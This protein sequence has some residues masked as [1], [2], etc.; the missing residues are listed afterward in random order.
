M[1]IPLATALFVAGA[2]VIDENVASAVGWG[3]IAGA[4]ALLIT[5]GTLHR[6]RTNTLLQLVEMRKRGVDIRNDGMKLNTQD[7]LASWI[8]VV[9]AWTEETIRQIG[10]V[11]LVDSEFFKTLNEVA[12]FT[13]NCRILDPQHDKWLREHNERLHRLE[14][15]IQK[16][17]GSEMPLG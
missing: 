7:K 14:G 2:R 5:M 17:G 6:R 9:S 15:L 12:P 13:L 1:A 11:S 3:L 16:Y 8:S 10:K 4:S